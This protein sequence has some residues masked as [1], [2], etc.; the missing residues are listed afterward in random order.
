MREIDMPENNSEARLTGALRSLSTS[1]ST[2]APAEI[3]EVLL[4]AF[5]RHHA[6]RRVRRRA[7]LAAAF[8]GVLLSAATWLGLRHHSVE[9]VA[10]PPEPVLISPLANTPA[11]ETAGATPSPTPTT[12]TRATSSGGHVATAQTE[13][14]DLPSSREAVRGESLAV[15]RLELTGR[16]LRILGA[17]VSDDSEDRRLLADFIVGQDGTPYAVRLV[18]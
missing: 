2:S 13:F 8:C 1:A 5:R 3:G 4:G 16:A 17:P 9:I 18:H 12:K 10:K 11:V 14:V 15:V 6:R 7:A